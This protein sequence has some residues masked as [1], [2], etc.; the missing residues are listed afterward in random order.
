V[1]RDTYEIVL[2]L[3]DELSA[4]LKDIK[5]KLDETKAAGKQTKEEVKSFSDK[6]RTATQ[7]VREFS[8]AIGGLMAFGGVAMLV[9]RVAGE[10]GEMEK[11]YAKL[12]PESQKAAGSLTN[13]NAAMLEMKARQ[14]AVVASVLNPVRAFFLDIID[15]IGQ[16]TRE[17]TNFNAEMKL[18]VD[19]YTSAATKQYKDEREALEVLTKARKD[20][21]AALSEQAEYLKALNIIRANKPVLTIIEGESP[22]Q[23]Q[24]RLLVKTILW[25]GELDKVQALYD[26]TVVSVR[27]TGELTKEIPV[28]VEEHKK[29]LVEVNDVAVKVA[30]YAE[31]SSYWYESAMEHIKT[32]NRLLAE[33]LV[34]W[35]AIG[36]EIDDSITALASREGMI[37]EPAAIKSPAWSGYRGW[38]GEAMSAAR[39]AAAAEEA[40]AIKKLEEQYKD[41]FTQIADAAV[42]VGTLLAEGNTEE[43]FKQAMKMAATLITQNAIAAAAAAAAQFN[44]PLMAFWLGVA[45][46]GIG[47]SIVGGMGGGE[48]DTGNGGSTLPYM[49]SGGI[50]RSP[51]LAMIGE[52]GPEAIIPLGEGRIGGTTIIVQGSI[53]AAKDLARELAGIQGRW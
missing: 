20:H 37:A 53:W 13:W 45:G 8:R 26:K 16:A 7:P 51:T 18:L 46:V 50:V 29:K 47:M 41:L 4:G 10:I 31:V 52:K 32:E 44:W 34:E 25:Q 6:I 43:A 30:G 28:W 35:E 14:G 38:E 39:I 22:M 15:P 2:K 24:D 40:T 21:S 1:D 33:Q 11:A 23:A 17:V 36:R 42:V 27:E 48:T 9:N 3:K 49:A 12:Y 5:D 19:K